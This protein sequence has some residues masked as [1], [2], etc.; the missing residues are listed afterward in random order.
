ME[1]YPGGGSKKI[2]KKNLNPKKTRYSGIEFRSLLR[3][4]F[5]E[6]VREKR[7]KAIP[8]GT[9]RAMIR[10]L[11]DDA[12]VSFAFNSSSDYFINI[13]LFIGNETFT[14]YENDGSFGSF[15]LD[16]IIKE[17]TED[18]T[19][20]TSTSD[21]ITSSPFRSSV[22]IGD[23]SSNT[24]N[25]DNL[26]TTLESGKM[27]CNNIECETLKTKKVII[28]K[29]KKEDKAM[30][31]FNIEFGACDN[32]KVHMSMYGIAIKNTNGTWVSYDKVNKDIINVDILNFDAGKFMYKMPVAIHD[33]KVG[34][35][36][37]HNHVPMF[38][39][40]VHDDTLTVVDVYVGEQKNIIPTKNMFGFNFI[41]KIVSLFDMG[42]FGT[43][44][45]D[46]PFGNMLPLL[47][48]SD[49]KDFDPMMLLMMN[50]N[51]MAGFD[52]SNPLIMYMLMKDGGKDSDMLPLLLMMGQNKPAHKCDCGKDAACD[53]DKATV[54]G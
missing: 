6:A 46:Q 14:F 52:M 12:Y 26:T 48:M 20:S 25:V 15:L 39:T 42:G 23:Y 51:G 45:E 54:E 35:V 21:I 8:Y 13:E 33:V 43:P 40:E 22:T 4:E 34:D 10:A 50:G 38:V 18:M 49:E 29:E 1:I 27:Y 28:E 30:K 53:C 44:S 32:G 7:Y 17:D 31:T 37:S 16:K 47:M 9:W 11:S 2:L 19:Y 41:T 3:D 36:V 24:T 5:T